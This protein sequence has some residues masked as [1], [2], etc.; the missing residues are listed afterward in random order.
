MFK[1]FAPVLEQ[2]NR[3]RGVVLSEYFIGSGQNIKYCSSARGRLW[4]SNLL[5]YYRL[6]S[7]NIISFIFSIRA[8]FIPAVPSRFL[9][10]YNYPDAHLGTPN[11]F[12]YLKHTRLEK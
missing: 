3:P 4:A 8:E 9:K 1:L 2:L 10:P 5:N 11:A 7:I 12:I 6:Q